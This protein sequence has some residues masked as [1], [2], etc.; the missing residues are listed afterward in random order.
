MEME[1]AGGRCGA[2]GDQ[3][4][5][6]RNG[7]SQSLGEDNKKDQESNRDADR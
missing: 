7:H 3:G 1:H 6:R 4:Q 2:A 5:R